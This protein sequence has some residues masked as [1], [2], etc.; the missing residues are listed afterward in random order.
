MGIKNRLTDKGRGRCNK[1]PKRARNGGNQLTTE[2]EGKVGAEKS[3]V[4]PKAG[5]TLEKPTN[6]WLRGQID[7]E[8]AALTCQRSRHDG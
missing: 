1:K 7:K 6:S 8:K 3:V 4:I 5:N 2:K